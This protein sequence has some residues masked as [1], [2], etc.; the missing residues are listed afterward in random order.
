MKFV[1]FILIQLFILTVSAQQKWEIQL[2]STLYDSRS[3]YWVI[4]AYTVQVKLDSLEAN[5]RRNVQN[6]TNGIA[7]YG[8]KDSNLVNYYTATAKRYQTAVN[9]MESAVDSFDL[10]SLVV[11]D[12]LEDVRLNAGNSGVVERYVK[13]VVEQG[14]AIVFYKGKRIYTL[15]CIS[16]LSALSKN[17]NSEVNVAEILNRGHEIRTYFESPDDCI[18][19]E[20]YILGW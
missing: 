17:A 16:E 2:K 1:L 3:G 7:Y 6:C 5:F 14:N 12:G 11:Y 20:Y 18:F 10:K 13:Q 4:G 15:H 19:I 9:Q 8:D